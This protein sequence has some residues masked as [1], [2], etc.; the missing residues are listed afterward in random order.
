MKFL[1]SVVAFFFFSFSSLFVVAGDQLPT[2]FPQARRIVAIGDVH[3]DLGAARSALVLAGAIGE[4][5]QWIGGD[6]VVVQTGDQLD[7]GDEE[8]AILDFFYRLADE[9][10][11][12][13]GAFHILNGNHELMNIALDLRY[14]TPGGYQDFADTPHNA[15]DPELAEYKPEH[16]GRVAAFRP[17]GPYAMM[18]SKRN[19]IV[20][21]GDSAFVHGGILPK[22][23]DYGLEKFNEEVRAW[24]AGTSPKPVDIQTKTSPVWTR[25]YSMGP[26]E[27]ACE[28]LSETLAALKVNRLVVGHTVQKNGI[29]S[30]CNDQVWCVDVGMA[31]FYGGPIQ[32]LEILDGKVRIIQ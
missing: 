7:R 27:S 14:V 6:L 8:Q 16:R 20:I 12:A 32:V 5:D 29:Q 11:G 31:A 10:Q 18:F 9:A 13:G 1:S 21:V 2:R 17:G 23:V 30:Y 3:G 25:L 24:A 19:T 4:K 15:Q 26:D 28:T 22:H